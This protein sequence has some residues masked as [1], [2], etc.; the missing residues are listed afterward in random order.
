MWS[1]QRGQ[2]ICVIVFL[3]PQCHGVRRRTKICPSSCL[4]SFLYGILLPFVSASPSRGFQR[5]VLLPLSSGSFGRVAPNIFHG[6]RHIC[7]AHNH[8]LSGVPCVGSR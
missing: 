6:Q 1:A 2:S 3:G 4:G 8:S 7:V 5:L